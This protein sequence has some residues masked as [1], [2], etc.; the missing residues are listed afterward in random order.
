M[1]LKKIKQLED[2]NEELRELE[3]EL[4]DQLEEHRKERANLVERTFLEFKEFFEG[5]E[6]KVNNNDSISGSVRSLVA[7]YKGASF[8]ITLH[9][10]KFVVSNGG[11]QICAV[12]IAEKLPRGSRM[13]FSVT[14]TSRIENDIKIAQQK[15]DSA[16][17]S[18][19]NLGE[20][21]YVYKDLSGNNDYESFTEILNKYFQ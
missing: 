18:L 3:K 12:I 21:E 15:I 17:N 20:Y 10:E 14:G 5:R 2:L 11:S 16:K 4:Y 13:S 7:V 9:D 19:N 1:D 8:S 6:F